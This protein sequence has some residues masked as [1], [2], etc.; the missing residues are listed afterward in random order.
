MPP[1]SPIPQDVIDGQ[2]QD[3]LLALSSGEA[4]HA[5]FLRWRDADPRHHAAFTE[6]QALWHDLAPLEPAFAPKGTTTP[7]SPTKARPRM[8]RRPALA[9][10]SACVLAVL[11]ML[12][13]PD[14]LADHRT[15]IGQRISVT[16][17][18]GSRVQLNSD[19]ALDL[20]FSA[21][22]RRVILR[23][24]EA[25]FEVRK[26]AARPFQVQ[27]AGG[28]TTAIG[29]VFAVRDTAHKIQVAVTEGRVRV[30][31]G[32]TQDIEVTSG[33]GAQYRPGTPPSLLPDL[34]VNGQTAWTRGYL[35]LRDLPL[36][37]ALAEIERYRPGRIVLWPPEGA[38]TPVSARIALDE[39]DDGIDALAATQGLSVTRLTPYLVLVR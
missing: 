34:D 29:T 25:L 39:L 31:T 4:D 21:T 8:W 38:G 28:T 32:Q 35:S 9:F 26:D 22:R 27:A 37:A 30:G 20:D 19:T 2:A 36:E 18:D 17:S 7:R 3:W 10:V 12:V 33:Q 13:P 6:L 11:I 16:L 15:A 1:L 24:G 23:R 5:A 14:F